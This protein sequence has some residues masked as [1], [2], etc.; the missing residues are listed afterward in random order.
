MTMDNFR[1]LVEIANR[2]SINKTAEA[3]YVTQPYLSQLINKIEKEVGFQ[4][5]IRSKTATVPTKEGQIFIDSANRILKEYETILKIPSLLADGEKISCA[6]IYSKSLMQFF[7]EFQKQHPLDSQTDTYIESSMDDIFDLIIRGLC[8]MGLIAFPQ[9]NLET[10]ETF[11]RQNNLCMKVLGTNIP[12][13]A[14]YSASNPLSGKKSLTVDEIKQ[15]P[16]VYYTNWK[17]SDLLKLLGLNGHNNILVVSDRGSYF[18]AIETGGYIS[19]SIGINPKAFLSGRLRCSEIS[20]Y[21]KKLFLGC[22]YSCHRG[23][24]KR[25][26]KFANYLKKRL[27]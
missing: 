27:V 12:I 9:E 11:M 26:L 17:N 4:I 1:Y 3:L 2:G 7:F 5:F 6:A 13:I 15:Y 23:L 24:K 10:Y 18:D 19:A 25:E 20:G 14:L 8:N 16:F 22:I 21:E